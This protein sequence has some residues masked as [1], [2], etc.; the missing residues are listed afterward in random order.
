M[1]QIPL[2]YRFGISMPVSKYCCVALCCK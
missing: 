1:R 2:K